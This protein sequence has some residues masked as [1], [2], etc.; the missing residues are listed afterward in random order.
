MPPL[1][2]R[3]TRIREMHE[4]DTAIERRLDDATQRALDARDKIVADGRITKS[5]V[6]QIL[7]LLH[8]VPVIRAD[9]GE[10][11]RYNRQIN[12]EYHRLASERNQWRRN[13]VVALPSADEL[14]EAA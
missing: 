10:S 2:R 7:E 14:E 4:D 5:D 13:K 1:T 8:L 11:L 6:P 12:G 9:A 3:E